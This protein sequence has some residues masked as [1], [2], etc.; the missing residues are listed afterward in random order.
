MVRGEAGCEAAE[1]GGGISRARALLYL[2]SWRRGCGGKKRVEAER[3]EIRTG[4]GL[5]LVGILCLCLCLWVPLS[6]VRDI[7]GVQHSLQAAEG[8]RCWWPGGVWLLG[9]AGR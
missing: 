9:R 2:A 8:G 6:W 5:R 4:V 3:L 7:H 1:K